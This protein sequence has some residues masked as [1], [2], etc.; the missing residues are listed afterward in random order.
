MINESLISNLLELVKQDVF[1]ALGCTEPIAVAYAS[2][3]ARKHFNGTLDNILIRVSKNIYKNGKS[4]MI[5][6]VNESGLDLAAALGFL[7]GNTDKV[8]MVLENVDDES[9]KVA[10]DM[11]S[12]GQVQVEY[13]KDSP[14]IYVY[15]KAS[16]SDSVV[17]V[18]LKDSHTHI[19]RIIENGKVIYEAEEDMGQSMSANFLK[20]MTLKDIRQVCE[21]IPIEELEFI[22]DG[23]DMNRKAAE[24]GM[25]EQI[26]I[27]MG[28]AYSKLLEK[29]R[30]TEDSPT[31]ARV[32]TAAACDVRMSGGN[33]PIMTSGGSGNQGLGVVLP[34]VV[35]GEDQGIEREKLLRAV[36]MGHLV[37]RYVK[38]FT[39]KLSGMCGCAIAAGIGASAGI[40][41]MLGGDDDKISGACTNMLANLTGM[42]CDGAKETC[43]LKLS[44]SACEAV[45][46]A[47]L[48]NEGVTIR[49]NVGIVGSS[50][51]ETIK[52]VGVLARESFNGVDDL[53]IDLIG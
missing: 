49:N 10:H 22:E 6:K 29:G 28:Y 30:L 8:F 43:A 44:T 47:Y 36:L 3:M 53:I 52:N 4:V 32:L 7:S 41:W 11:I 1:P 31:R 48:A 46:S 19:D 20:D 45:I 17:E 40:T 37:N 27:N 39:G 14:D 38:T 35:V 21:L 9:I 5:P 51:E 34:I 15:V 26:G 18:G 42:I 24:K 2:A 50:I 23:I 16:G 25:N 13:L 12:S 33:C